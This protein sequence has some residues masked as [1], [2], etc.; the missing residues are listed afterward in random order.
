MT[1]HGGGAIEAPV[2]ERAPSEWASRGSSGWRLLA[3]VEVIA[4]TAA[5]VA[6]LVVPTIV[7][8]LL[9]AV[10][11][12]ARRERLATVGLTRL[13]SGW[14]GALTILGWVVAWT[15]VQLGLVMPALNHLTGRTQDLSEMADVEGS[16]GLL[17]VFLLLSWTIAAFGEELVYRGYL[18][19]R[20]TDVL[21]SGTAGVV[22]AVVG[23]SVLFG[24]AHT[25]QGLVGVVV[26]FLDALFLSALRLHY[27]T[28]WAS[29]LA[30]GF[31]NTI[32]LVA[33]FLVGPIYGFW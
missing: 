8:L 14:H 33:L 24:L 3:A 20:L 21:G 11:L 10:S 19:T 17:L 6:N 1:A 13:A 18:P 16:V 23:S 29:I 30:H 7:I 25:E 15:L 32:G 31:N 26:T 4:A 2:T 22:T 9:M 28:V 12:L 27:R 5:I